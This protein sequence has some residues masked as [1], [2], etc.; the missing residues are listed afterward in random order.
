MH[1]DL[2]SIKLYVYFHM[3]LHILLQAKAKIS[4]KFES[5][6]KLSAVQ[7]TDQSASQPSTCPGGISTSPSKSSS[8]SHRSTRSRASGW[9]STRARPWTSCSRM[10]GMWLR[11]QMPSYIG[12]S[13]TFDLGFR[14]SRPTREI[15]SPP[16]KCEKRAW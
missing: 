7:S 16:E 6:G 2:A 11:L 12:I 14:S 4:K 5:S 10:S 8:S 13:N 9:K 1:S 3:T 15:F